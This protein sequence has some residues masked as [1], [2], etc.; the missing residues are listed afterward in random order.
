MMYLLMEQL[1][2]AQVSLIRGGAFDEEAQS[3]STRVR[4]W[5]KVEG[6]AYS[7]IR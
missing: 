3:M 5:D 1:Q 7:I 6:S 2:Q 4:T